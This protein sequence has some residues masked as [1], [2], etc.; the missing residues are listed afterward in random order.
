MRGVY[1]VLMFIL[2][3]VLFLLF[4]TALTGPIQVESHEM[5]EPISDPNITEDLDEIDWELKAQRSMLE[6]SVN[7]AKER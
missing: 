1:D 2:I 4:L 7:M 5:S 3:A 6:Q